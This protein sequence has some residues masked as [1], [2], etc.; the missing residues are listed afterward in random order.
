MAE[1]ILIIFFCEAGLSF[2]LS[3]LCRDLW[4]FCD[5]DHCF[6]C[7]L[8]TRVEISQPEEKR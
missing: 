4:S 3:P 2:S 1:Q 6:L 7:V 5:H 8:Y